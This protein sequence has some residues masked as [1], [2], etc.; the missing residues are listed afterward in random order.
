MASAVPALCSPSKIHRRSTACTGEPP[1][2]FHCHFLILLHKSVEISSVSLQRPSV[3]LVKDAH[4]TWNFSTVGARQKSAPSQDKQQFSLG[5]LAVHDGQM[6]IQIS[7]LANRDSV[8]PHQSRLDGFCSG[9][10]I[11]R[12]SG[13]LGSRCGAPIRNAFHG[14]VG[15]THRLLGF[16]VRI[17]FLASRYRHPHWWRE[18][19]LGGGSHL[20]W[21]RYYARTIPNIQPRTAAL[22]ARW[23]R[24]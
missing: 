2:V 13:A 21:A 17:R 23:S 18:S 3:E 14:R 1:R 8:R 22:V 4:G 10:S 5:E 16:E 20:D 7:R 9:Y 12:R 6:A 15:R 24:C 19:R 11:C